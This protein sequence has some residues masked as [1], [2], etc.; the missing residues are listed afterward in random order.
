VDNLSD[1]GRPVDNLGMTW[2][3]RRSVI[4]TLGLVGI[5]CAIGATLYGRDGDRLG[6]LLLWLG[7]LVFV[8]V[9]AY[10]S[11]LNPRLFANEVGVEVRT[12][13]GVRSAEWRHVEARVTTTR[14]LGRDTRTLELELADADDV[15][16]DPE[17]VVLGQF[18]LGAEPDDVLADLNRL[19]SS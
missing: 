2:G 12:M 18:E 6:A 13:K 1:S 4:V 15:M 3:P 16:A 19:R 11:L 7:A 9:T 5:G 14:R 17:L 8:A 10:G